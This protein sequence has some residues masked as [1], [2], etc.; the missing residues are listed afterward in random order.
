MR[1]PIAATP[2]VELPVVDVNET[3]SRFDKAAGDQDA[4]TVF[5]M[6]VTSACFGRL[7]GLV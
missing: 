4:L 5:V 6:P 3:H 1:I 7:L 2:A